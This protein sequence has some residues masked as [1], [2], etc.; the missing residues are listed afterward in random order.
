MD[1]DRCK[2]MQTLACRQCLINVSFFPKSH[3]ASKEFHRLSGDILRNSDPCWNLYP[4]PIENR[5]PLIIPQAPETYR[6]INTQYLM[7]PSDVHS[8]EIKTFLTFTKA[9]GWHHIFQN[10]F[11][12][13]VLWLRW[14]ISRLRDEPA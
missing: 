7:R 5:S 14:G 10:K 1:K 2:I 8:R 4:S 9:F 12:S 6:Y 13:A 11:S 3:K